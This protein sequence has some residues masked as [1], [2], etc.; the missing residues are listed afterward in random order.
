MKLIG[1]LKFFTGELLLIFALL[2]SINNY[3]GRNN[4]QIKADGAGYYDY[5]PSVFIYGDLPKAG[6]KTVSERVDKRGVYV[7]YKNHRLNKYPCGVSV[8]V[9]PFFVYAH[10][11]APM[12]GFAN[13][14][15]SQPYQDAVFYA[16]IFYLFISLF[17]LKR[18]LLFYTDSRASVFL[19]QCL[20]VFS[21]SMISYV[22]Y[23]AA[24]SHVY[25]FFA[26]TTFLYFVKKYFADKKPV[27]FLWACAFFG[28]VIILRQ[29]N[30]IVL[31]FVP[32]LA[33]SAAALKENVSAIWKN[34]GML[35]KG[36][37]LVVALFCLQVYFWHRQTGECVVFSYQ[38]E[39]FN[40]LK[41]AF[42]DI[43]FSYKKGLFVYTPVFFVAL[44]GLFLYI[45][46]KQFYL[47]FSWLLFFVL[48]TYI[49][50]SWWCW[51]YGCSYGL[52]AYVDFYAIFCILLAVLLDIK[53]WLKAVLVS[54]LLLTVPVNMIQ[55]WQY[56]RYILDWENM[57]KQKY[58]SVFLRT[59][60]RFKGLVWKKE[61]KLDDQH[62]K[63]VY[64]S[65][66]SNKQVPEMAA[67]E[68]YSEN[69][70]FTD[71]NIVQVHF[72]NQ[73]LSS[74]NAYIELWIINPENGAVVYNSNVPLI[75]FSEKG[76][77]QQQAGVYNFEV[78]PFPHEYQK[79]ILKVN[80]KTNSEE[81]KNLQVS[82]F[83]YKQ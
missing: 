68:V 2:F 66:I 76:L 62:S 15:F 69:V 58:W 46:K 50:S 28:L 20:V 33:G 44:F 65:S 22:Y 39:S 63:K 67:A 77:N 32:F 25:S 43:L 75:H 13:D 60:D 1:K 36:I 81:L 51:W 19:I 29:V 7:S 14:G 26:I 5:L 3:F 47:F 72:E 71:A 55:T 42:S 16:A 4:E 70:A 10:L 38:G 34:K 78:P 83:I 31:F 59:A 40:F 57:D 12:Q 6:D 53:K 21:T 49:L 56:K 24:F 79:V 41:P 45:R 48:L 80:A 35:A 61:F 74:D 23:D 18:L 27:D 52:R 37:L 9:F 11:T 17:F 54:L 64:T 30:V 82:Y 8:L 73:F